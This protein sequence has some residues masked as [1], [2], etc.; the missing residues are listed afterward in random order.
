MIYLIDGHNLI[1][2]MPDIHLSDPDDEEKLVHRLQSWVAGDPKRR[3]HIIFDNG[4]FGGISPQLSGL[5][6]RVEYARLGR[7][8]DDELIRAL[9]HLNNPQEYTLITS[10]RE[11][12]AVARKRRVGYIL[13]EEFVALMAADATERLA[14]QDVPPEAEHDPGTRPE[15]DV[16]TAEVEEW[17]QVFDKPIPSTR[18][19]RQS[20]TEDNTNPKPGRVRSPQE[21]KADG[22]IS[23]EDLAAWLDVFG[24]VPP[25][26][27]TSKAEPDTPTP[28]PADRPQPKPS[29]RRAPKKRPNRPANQ[30]KYTDDKLSADEVDEWLDI[31][32]DLDNS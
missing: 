3:I 20:P 13:S 17:L 14:L 25:K 9:K 16:S 10:D 15:V 30:Q 24:E 7:T 5:R 27:T 19:R 12:L 22:R 4:E 28:P 18:P 21:M 6:V 32:G 8:A 11:I 2:K 23:E 1:G 26:P 29:P 31:F